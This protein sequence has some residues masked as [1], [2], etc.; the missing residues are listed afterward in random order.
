MPA[1]STA[2]TRRHGLWFWGSLLGWFATY[3]LAIAAAESTTWPQ[4]LRVALA[5]VPIPIFASFLAA[6]VTGVRGMDE[7]E[8]RIHLEA[9]AIAFPLGMLLLMT[10]GLLQRVVELSMDDWSYRHVWGYF[11][12]LYLLGLAFARRRYL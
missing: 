11:P 2:E 10:L 1:A 5:L 12:V 4:W 8:R 3:I 9:L 6:L 7:L